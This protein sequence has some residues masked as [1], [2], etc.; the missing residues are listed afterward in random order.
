MEFKKITTEK[1]T[2]LFR[3]KKHKGQ[4]S[5]YGTWNGFD[6][7]ELGITPENARISMWERLKLAGWI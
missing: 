2:L 7:Y 4:F 3:I 1:F 6:M 5:C